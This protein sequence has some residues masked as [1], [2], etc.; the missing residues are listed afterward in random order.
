MFA[1]WLYLCHQLRLP[2]GVEGFEMDIAGQPWS[3]CYFYD[4]YAAL[5][6][7]IGW[8]TAGAL[9][10]AM[11]QRND[12]ALYVLGAA[13]FDNIALQGL[14]LLWYEGW[15]HAKYTTVGAHRRFTYSPR[16]Y[17]ATLT[18]ALALPVYFGVGLVL[19]VR[20]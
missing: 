16:R 1:V 18:M 14:V 20:G 7:W 15:C 12:M 5:E 8:L 4:R 2:E 3:F 11:S 17:A 19:L 13:L 9:V 6:R 10:M